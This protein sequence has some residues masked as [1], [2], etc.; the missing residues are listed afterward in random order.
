M[1]NSTSYVAIKAMIQQG[2][3][4][5]SFPELEKYLK[6]FE[7]K[8]LITPAEYKD[9]LNLAQKLNHVQQRQQ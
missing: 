5:M 1:G 9:L 4:I 6:T 8:G 7:S 2:W 3:V